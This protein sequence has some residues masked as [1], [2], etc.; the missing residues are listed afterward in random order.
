MP[1]LK[2]LRHYLY[3][4]VGGYLQALSPRMTAEVNPACSISFRPRMVMPP[5]VVTRSISCSGCD[6]LYPALGG[7]AQI[8]QGEGYAA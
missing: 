3:F 5:G 1:Q 2:R 8:A 6:P 4:A 7:G